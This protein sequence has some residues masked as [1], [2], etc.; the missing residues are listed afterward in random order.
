MSQKKPI[1]TVAIGVSVLCVVLLM[2]IFA[3]YLNYNSMLQNKDSEIQSLKNQLADAGLEP[4]PNQDITPDTS[5]KDAQIANL[6]NQIANLQSQLTQK[7]ADIDSLNSQIASLN[8]QINSLKSAEK[9]CT[10]KQNE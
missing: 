6:Q 10:A 7:N 3:I 8:S 4:N 2:A 5:D 1:N 9:M